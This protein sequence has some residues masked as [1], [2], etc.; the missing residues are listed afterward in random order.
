[1]AFWIENRH[2]SWPCLVHIVPLLVCH[3]KALLAGAAVVQFNRSQAEHSKQAN[4][5]TP[6]LILDALEEPQ[7]LI[8]SQCNGL[9]FVGSQGRVGSL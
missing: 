4:R 1:M 7:E 5:R 6:A 2:L 8:V 9:A 3:E